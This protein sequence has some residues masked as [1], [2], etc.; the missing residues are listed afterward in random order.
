MSYPSWYL[1]AFYM[2]FNIDYRIIYTIE[3]EITQVN[4]MHELSTF[5]S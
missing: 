3:H 5:M 4:Q 2:L 1:S